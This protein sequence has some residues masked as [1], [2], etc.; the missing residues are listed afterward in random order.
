MASS[1]VFQEHI[2]NHVL[3]NVVSS[4][5]VGRTEAVYNVMLRNENGFNDFIQAICGVAGV[6]RA[7]LISAQGAAEA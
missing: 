3:I 7:V 5:E 2:K 1:R 4:P 6:E